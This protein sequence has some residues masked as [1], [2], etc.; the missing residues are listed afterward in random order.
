R[1]ARPPGDDP[2]PSR[3]LARRRPGRPRARRR[4]ARRHRRAGRRRGRARGARR[5]G[6][7]RRRGRRAEPPPAQPRGRLLRADRP[8]A[9]RRRQRGRAVRLMPRGLRAALGKDLRLLVRDR[10]GLVFLTLAPIVVITVAGVSLANLYGDGS[11]GGTAFV[12][13]VVD[14]DGGGIERALREHLGA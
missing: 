8:R 13:P 4:R 9:P 14:E 5:G 3:G 11:R 6:P 12:L 2:P 7:E 1:A 10:V